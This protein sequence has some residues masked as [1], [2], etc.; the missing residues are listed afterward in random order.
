MGVDIL[1][2]VAVIALTLFLFAF[3]VNMEAVFVF[4]NKLKSVPVQEQDH[5]LFSY[6]EKLFLT[7][8]GEYTVTILIGNC[9][10]LTVYSLMTELLLET[11][12]SRWNIAF[13]P[14]FATLVIASV[15]IIF[16]AGY[17][18]KNIPK[19]NSVS[20]YRKSIFLTC[21]FYLLFY[22]VSR[23]FIWFSE[24]IAVKGKGQ[25]MKS[26][27]DRDDLS[28]LV[29]DMSSNSDTDHKEL[30]IFRNALDFSD[31]RVRDCMSRRVEIEAVGIES[32]VEE[33]KAVFVDTNFSRLPV[34]RDSIDHIIGYIHIKDLLKN[35]VSITDM[36]MDVRFVPE[37]MLAQNLLAAFIKDKESL[38]I[39]LD[40]FGGTAGLITI[41]DILEEIFGEIE[42][43]HDISSMVEKKLKDGSYLFSERLEEEYLNEKYRLGI[44][45]NEEY[46]TLAGYIIYRNGGF[47]KQGDTVNI[48]GIKMDILR[49][50]A[51]KIELIK[52][53]F[54]KNEGN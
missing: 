35:P 27:F 2:I 16:I 6:I 37:T 30:E 9:I 47:P 40:E 31:L 36:L 8:P 32:T 52:Y 34:Y 18:P 54:K 14:V 17:A 11:L 15:V 26:L 39:V 49:M 22:P 3:F 28:L 1:Y 12:F 10:V 20:V 38:A 44:P 50:N 33:A 24:R 13:N 25:K 46:D 43:E 48:D 23:F 19:K 51:S 45:E 7:H 5:P 41:E 4:Y 53:N 21:F 42:D 29:E